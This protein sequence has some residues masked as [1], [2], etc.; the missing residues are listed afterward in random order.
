MTP[1]TGARLLGE[2]GALG[3]Y[4]KA[5]SG[6]DWAAR[7]SAAAAGG[8]GFIELSVD[9]SAPKLAR[10]EWSA[11][12]RRSV[13]ETAA[14]AGV[15]VGTIVLSAHRTFPW[16][17]ADEGLRAR[18][19]CL[20]ARAIELAADLGADRV[21]LAGYF[22]F[23]GPRHARARE[24]FI[25]GVRRAAEA[26]EQRGIRLAIENMDGADVLSA[27]DATLLVREIDREVVRLYPD[28]GNF[29]GN[30]FDAVVE[31]RAVLPFAEAVQLKDAK[32][33]EFR[34][35]PFGTGLV[36]W[37]AV[38]HLLNEVGWTGPVSVE[39]WNDEGDPSMAAEALT[40]LRAAV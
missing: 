29:A 30:G 13:R 37:P 34:R 14:A 1:A 25:A 36:D 5:L 23:E 27:T 15:R 9:D 39:M 17:S 35:V 31:L 7:C 3:I 22:T 8:Y 38:L 4:E 6:T 33:G 40:W 11:T 16:G 32:R 2:A 28:V 10:L 18:A 19:D 12:D 20:A 26:A 24:C 21:Q